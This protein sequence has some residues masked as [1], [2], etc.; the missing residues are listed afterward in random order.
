MVSQEPEKHYRGI[1]I[2]L[3]LIATLDELTAISPQLAEKVRQHFDREV[4][5]ALRSARVMRKR[6]N[7]RARCDTYGFYDDR[8]RFV[9]K[10]VKIKTDSGRSIRSDCVTV[11]AIS[12]GLEN[13][14]RLAKAGPRWKR[15]TS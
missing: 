13:E 8:W 15:E 4:L 11:D 1:S 5:I 14:R 2:G 6:M 10:D 7:F 9:L 3:S 12:T